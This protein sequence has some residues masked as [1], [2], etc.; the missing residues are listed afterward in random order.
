MAKSASSYWQRFIKHI[1]VRELPQLKTGARKRQIFQR[2]NPAAILWFLTIIVAMFLW[3]PKLL[4][5]CG[6]GIFVMLFV[7]SMP[8]WDWSQLWLQ[9]RNFTQTTNG[10][11]VLSVISGAIACLGTYTAMTMW[12]NAPNVWVGSGAIVQGLATLVTLLLLAQLLI[13]IYGT[14]EQEQLENLLES[15]TDTDPLKRLIS[16]RKLTKLATSKPLEPNTKKIMIECLH[17]FLSSES[18]AA[19]RDAAFDSLQALEPNEK[20]S[21]KSIGTT[22]VPFSV[23]TKNKVS[24]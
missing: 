16:V 8:R 19:I 18:E 3:N 13:S 10:R 21:K 5:S 22:L 2:N 15:L 4:F 6:S 12:A 24:C 9:I 11:L 1:P 14:Q 23:K 20:L 7:Y 17:L